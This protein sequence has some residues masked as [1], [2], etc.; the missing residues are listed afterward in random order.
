M[1]VICEA[2][3]IVGMILTAVNYMLLYSQKFSSR[4]KKVSQAF[5]REKPCEREVF[6]YFFFRA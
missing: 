3:L 6:F 1:M 2:E 5:P 4:K